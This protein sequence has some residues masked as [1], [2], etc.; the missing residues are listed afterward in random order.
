[1][2][3]STI[4]FTLLLAG[5]VI[6]NLHAQKT[7]IIDYS[8][9]D[10][11]AALPTKADSADL[12]PGGVGKDMQAD[13]PVDVFF[14]Y[15]TSYT[16]AKIYDRMNAPIDDIKINTDTDSRSIKYQAS[17]FNQVG[18]IY[19]PRYRQAHISA[20][21]T[22]DTAAARKALD[23]AYQD[24]QDAF[25]YY[26]NF[27]NHGRPFIIASHSQGTTHA[28]RLIKKVIQNKTLADRLVV[29]YL[30]GMPVRK[31]ELELPLCDSAGQTNCF[32][33]WR[34]FREGYTPK[35]I[36]NEPPVDVVNPISWSTKPG[37][38]P[39]EAN[40]GAV[41]FDFDQGVLPHIVQASIAGNVLWIKKPE[42]HGK[43]KFILTFQKNYHAGD[44]NLFYKDIQENAKL[45]TANY[46]AQHS[47]GE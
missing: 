32:C 4:L 8:N 38:T 46:L 7:P 13:A 45:R 9:P 35:Y 18:K 5:I 24:V 17:L 42:V 39:L 12:L 43:A 36:Q 14:L 30:A 31:G 44:F 37:F 6:T 40:K 25:Y 23:F 34:T 11:W 15:P 47:S 22:S 10:N 33:S 16:G 20:Y 19:A 2:K 28:I 21:Y 41:L 1:M 26:L 3:H 27:Y 29:A